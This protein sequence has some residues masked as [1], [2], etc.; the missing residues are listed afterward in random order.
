[1]GYELP[2]EM[3]SAKTHRGQVHRW[4]LFRL[5]TGVALP[6]VASGRA[7]EFRDR[8]WLTMSELV[9]GAVAFRRP[10]YHL[11]AAWPQRKGGA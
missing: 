11:V 9:A 2:V 5:R 3:R 8:R 6:P 7:P 4:F 1:M 10:V